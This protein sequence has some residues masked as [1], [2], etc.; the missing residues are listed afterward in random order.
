M[1]GWCQTMERDAEDNE[2][3]EEG[4][5]KWDEQGSEARMRKKR[6]SFVKLL[7][8]ASSCSSRADSKC[9]WQ[10]PDTHVSEGPAVF[11]PLPAKCGE[12]VA[13]NFKWT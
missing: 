1:E 8:H 10:R 2:L 3:P 11:P 12:Y 6:S 7:T 4:E 13:R 9:G 5:S